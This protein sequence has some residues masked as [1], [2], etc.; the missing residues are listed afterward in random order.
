MNSL[1]LRGTPCNAVGQEMVQID[2]CSATVDRRPSKREA[3]IATARSAARPVPRDMLRQKF[4]GS[5]RADTAPTACRCRGARLNSCVMLGSRRT[6]SEPWSMNGQPIADRSS[7]A[8]S[9]IESLKRDGQLGVELTSRV[10]Q[11]DSTC[12][13]GDWP[14]N[15]QSRTCEATASKRSFS[16]SSR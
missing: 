9:T 4:M 16:I 13:W 7:E 10:R 15:N 12:V 14:A 2:N 1:G 5:L 8:S 11:I 6:G 3:W